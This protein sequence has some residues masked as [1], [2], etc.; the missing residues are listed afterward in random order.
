MPRFLILDNFNDR[1]DILSVFIYTRHEPRV[2]A[3]VKKFL[4]HD[5]C[6]FKCIIC[7][8]HGIS[9]LHDSKWK[10]KCITLPSFLTC[11]CAHVIWL[12]PSF[13]SNTIAPLYVASAVQARMIKQLYLFETLLV[14]TK[15]LLNKVDFT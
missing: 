2:S 12:H 1:K 13:H 15:N 8:R 4:F 10:T 9:Q 11:V 7:R 3:K 6:E 14:L 5:L